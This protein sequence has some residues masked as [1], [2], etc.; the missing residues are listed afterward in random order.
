[1]ER[2]AEDLHFASQAS[3]A[4]WAFVPDYEAPGIAWPALAVALAGILGV[5]FVFVVSYTV[6]RTAKVRVRKY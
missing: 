1:L 5:A 6:D 4:S 3:M 2:V